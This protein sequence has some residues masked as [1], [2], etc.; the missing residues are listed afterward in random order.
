MNSR[1]Q[2]MEERISSAEDTTEEMDSSVKENIKSNKCLTQNIQL[3]W[4]IMKKPNLRTICIEEAEGVEL[5]STDNIF[6]KILEE[7][8]P[9]PKK[10][11][12]MKIQEAYRTPN[13]LNPNKKSSCHI[14][15]KTLNI[16]SKERIL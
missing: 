1:I 15:I 10:D 5:K 2:E 8:F 4:D 3:I 13:R 11:M 12:P 16:Q 7:N 6:L 9:S 14:T